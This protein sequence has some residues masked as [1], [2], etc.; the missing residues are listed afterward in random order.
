MQRWLFNN[1]SHL[2]ELDIDFLSRMVPEY[3]RKVGTKMGF[4]DPSKCGIFGMIDGVF[5]YE[6]MP[7]YSRM[8][9]TMAITKAMVLNARPLHCPVASLVTSMGV[10]PG[11]T[12]P[13]TCGTTDALPRM[14]DGR[15]YHI[16]GD[17]AYRIARCEHHIVCAFPRC[18]PRT[19]EE[20]KFNRALNRS[21][22]VVEWCFRIVNQVW[23]AMSF[24]PF[25]KAALTPSAVRYHDAVLLTNFRTCL[26]GGN[27][28]SFY[29][30]CK[31]PTLEEFISKPRPPGHNRWAEFAELF[32]HAIDELEEQNDE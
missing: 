8:Q 25:Q 29:F 2:N 21:R 11:A 24:K 26:K 14:P 7:R 18:D 27:Q 4:T 6:C 20:R 5:M 31:P 15:R 12:M 19:D 32:D 1:Y 13:H 10:F 16:I 30:K 28:I 22:V 3:A 23:Q 9:C 17:P